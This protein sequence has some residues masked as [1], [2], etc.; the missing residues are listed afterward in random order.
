MAGRGKQTAYPWI[1]MSA[2]GLNWESDLLVD[3]VEHMPAISN[4]S[5]V[6]YVN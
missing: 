1:H 3:V 6:L 4:E 5:K 2:N